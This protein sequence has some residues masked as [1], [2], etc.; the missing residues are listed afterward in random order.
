[1]NNLIVRL[2]KV[3]FSVACIMLFMVMVFAFLRFRSQDA[4]IQAVYCLVL[5]VGSLG[6]LTAAIFI[7]T[8]N[9]QDEINKDYRRMREWPKTK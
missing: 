9:K 7:V 5:A 3:I 2:F 8:D 1:M 4:C 6:L